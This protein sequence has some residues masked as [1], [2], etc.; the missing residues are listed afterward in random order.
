MS[1]DAA[2]RSDFTRFAVFLSFGVRLADLHSAIKSLVK[3]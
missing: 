2:F 3:S 1:I